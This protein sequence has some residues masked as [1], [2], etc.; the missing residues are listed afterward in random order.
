ML[1]T[2]GL[3][4]KQIAILWYWLEWK[5]TL[6][7]L[8]NH[9]INSKNITVLDKNSDIKTPNNIKNITWTNYNA[10]LDKYDIIFKSAWIP[11]SKELNPY[12]RKIINQIQFFFDNYKW[13]VIAITASKWK[14]TITSLIYSLLIN[15]WY[16][17]KL[18]WNIWNPVLDEVDLDWK[19]D[20]VVVELSSYMLDTLK[21]K[22][23]ISVLWSIFPEHL[24]RH[25][26]FKKYIKAKLNIL[27]W[28]EINII[29]H[30]TIKDFGLNKI[31]KNTISYWEK[32]LFGRKWAYFTENDSNIFSNKNRILEWNHNLDNISAMIAVWFQLWINKKIIQKTIKTFEWLPHR[33]QKI[34]IFHWIKFIDDAISTTPESTIQAIKTFWKEINTILLW[35]TDRWYDFSELVKIIK[36]NWIKNIVLFPESWKKILATFWTYIKKLNIL[37]TESMERAV[38]F[39][40]ENTTKWKI[41][42][43]STAS[44]SYSIWKNFEEKGYLF[45]QY[46]KN[47]KKIAKNNKNKYNR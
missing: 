19:Y 9:K 7:F 27:K 36:T 16:N 5:S 15:A 8:L 30:N 31:Y 3:I 11:I 26:N 10:N 34:W 43:L 22:N 4:E 25:W 42:L 20:Y 21:K 28:S 39:C 37:K 24:D 14:S 13:K 45:Q 18:V 33:M 40:I 46:V 44:P 35:W 1:C 41:C 17:A 23:F 32:W 12:K 47:H 29:N 6:Q 2:K 38:D